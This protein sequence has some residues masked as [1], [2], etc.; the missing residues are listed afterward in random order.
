MKRFLR[1]FVPLALILAVLAC[2]AWYFLIYDSALTQELLL[3][4]ARSQSDAGNNKFAA[5]LYDLAY[6]QSS[7][8][9]SVAIELADQYVS[10]GNYTQAEQAISDAIAENA[11]AE[12][13]AALSRLYVQQDKLLDAVNLLDTIPDAAIKAQ[14]DALRPQAPATSAE[15]G[16]HSQYISVEIT[17]NTGALYVSTTGEYPSI[18]TD[19][20][21]APIQLGVGETVLY[22]LAVSDDGLVSPLSIYGYTIDGVV[23]QVAFADEAIEAAVRTILG[24][25]S[26]T[27]LFTNDLWTIS[28][29]TIPAD[30]TTYEDLQLLN[31]LDTLHVDSGIGSELV[32]LSKLTRLQTLTVTNSTVSADVLA[33]VGTLKTLKHLTMTDCGISTV[34]TL[35]GLTALETLDLQGNTIRNL[36]PLSGMTALQELNLAGNA[37]TELSA[38]STLTNLKKLDVSYNSLSS[39]DPIAVITGLET[40][41]ASQNQIAQCAKLA[42][43]TKLTA[44]D[45]SHNALTDVAALAACTALT[46]LNLSNNTI[47]DITALY[48]LADLESFSFAYNQV[49]VL[50]EFQ[51]TCALVVLDAS[52][53]LLEVIDQLEG[54][55]MLNSVNLDYNEALE[56]LLP[57]D[58]CPVLIRVNAYGTLVTDVSFLTAKSV[59]VNFNPTLED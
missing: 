42:A 43:L 24:V 6:F 55:P 47:A 17:T 11:T 18:E 54:L 4:Q 14:L 21:E 58:S 56:S 20:C 8:D 59:L 31:R 10:I 34:A 2:T 30:A 41:N 51:D 12:L 16:F 13:Y 28:E 52:H 29:F 1:V 44:L 26:D 23:E 19:L 49:A 35:E 3:S 15:P 37:V 48:T 7:Q 25:G 53:N 33:A 40:L 38:L 57:L 46:D 45:L 27:V 50:P 39:L 5:W 32:H 22:C 36:A 9:G